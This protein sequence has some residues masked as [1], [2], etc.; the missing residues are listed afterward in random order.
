[1]KNILC[2]GDSNTY[3]VDI[4]GGGR[5][6]R[7]LRYTGLLQ[8]LLPDDFHIIEEGFNGRTTVFD[9]PIGENRNG[10]AFIEMLLQSHMPLDLVII[11]LGT[12]DVKVYFSAPAVTIAKGIRNI[13]R[14]IQRYDYSPY[15]APGILIVSP[16]TVGQKVEDGTFGGF[17]ISSYHKSLQLASEYKKIADELGCHFFDAASVASASPIDQ[18]HLDI[19]GHRLLAGALKKEI[20]TILS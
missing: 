4:I 8:E 3:G 11:M 10:I 6:E 5:L 13:C 2:F 20:L 15:S 14:K 16:I 19:E 12:N 1:M 18:I 17:D 7:N 9:D